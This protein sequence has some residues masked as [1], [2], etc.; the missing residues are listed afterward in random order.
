M[1]P[2]SMVGLPAWSDCQS[3]EVFPSSYHAGRDVKRIQWIL[4]RKL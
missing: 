3:A 4:M 2:A 1:V